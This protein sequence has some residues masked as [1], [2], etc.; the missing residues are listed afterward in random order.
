MSAQ[1][2]QADG[3]RK[4]W[5]AGMPMKEMAKTIGI[6]REKVTEVVQ[7]LS[8]PHRWPH[9]A[10]KTIDAPLP[11]IEDMDLDHDTAQDLWVAV[12]NQAVRDAVWYGNQRPRHP[13][14]ELWNLDWFGTRDAEIV[15]ER[16]GFDIE[17]LRPA[18]HDLRAR[19][20]AECEA[21]RR[22]RTIV[23]MSAARDGRSRA[24]AR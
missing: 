4:M 7:A 22:P 20:L 11:Q 3:F 2:M 1:Q 12:L 17:R 14:G 5:A 19:F 13:N 8:L 10:D 24:V 21:G 18:V 23:A 15:C 9:L 6:P 16:A